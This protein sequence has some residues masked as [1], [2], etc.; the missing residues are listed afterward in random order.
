MRFLEAPARLAHDCPVTHRNGSGDTPSD[1]PNS[2]LGLQVEMLPSEALKAYPGNARTH[3][4]KQI[5][6]IAK[7]LIDDQGGIIA[8]HGRA[9][10]AKRSFSPI[11]PTMYPLMATSAV[12]VVSGTAASRWVAVR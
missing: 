9:A 8:G 4:R 12:S 2:G 7:I 5:R 1:A 10:A 3:S 11:L 6:Q